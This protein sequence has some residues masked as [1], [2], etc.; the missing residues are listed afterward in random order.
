MIPEFSGAG[1]EENFDKFSPDI[2]VRLQLNLFKIF[3]NRRRRWNNCGIDKTK[4]PINSTETLG[5]LLTAFFL[6]AKRPG[7][8]RHRDVRQRDIGDKWG[9]SFAMRIGIM[10]ARE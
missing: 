6:I 2:A 5:N 3:S 1:P 7:Q 4:M 8:Y 10:I 9:L